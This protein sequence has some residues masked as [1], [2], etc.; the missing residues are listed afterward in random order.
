MALTL[1]TAPTD[2]VLL[3]LNDVLAFA[4]IDGQDDDFTVRALIRAAVG[5]L[6]GRDGFLGR[7]LVTQ[8]WKLT[9]CD[10]PEWEWCLPLPPLQS[11]SHIKYTNTSGVLTTVNS[12][13]YRVITDG[14]PCGMVI[15]VYG[16]AWPTDVRSEIGAVQVTFVAGYG[17]TAASVPEAIRTWLKRK[18]RALYD[19]TEPPPASDLNNW[20]VW[21]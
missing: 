11:V 20:R 6:D 3:P 4:R 2:G 17:D 18:V 12:A 19:G 14:D 15:P 13:T 9:A 21:S 16:G 7:A 10:F 1:V 5:E 8:T